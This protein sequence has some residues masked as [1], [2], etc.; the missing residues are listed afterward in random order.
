MGN[1]ITYRK[2]TKERPASDSILR[3]DGTVNTVSK[4]NPITS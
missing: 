3:V 1:G 4:R 2:P